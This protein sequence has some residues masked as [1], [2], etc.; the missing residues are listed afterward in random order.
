[1][2]YLDRESLDRVL[3]LVRGAADWSDVLRRAGVGR[4]RRRFP[5]VALVAAA[6]VV[7]VAGAASAFGTVRE[8]FFGTGVNS[9][10]AFIHNTRKNC[11]PHEL[12][13]M[14]ADGS[15][16]LRVARDVDSGFT[17]SPD[18]RQIAYSRIRRGYGH[19]IYVVNADG[20]GKRLLARKGLDPNWSPDGRR[21]VF[22]SHR[23]DNAE[24]YVMNADGSGQRNLTGTTTDDAH[25]PAWSPDGHT[26]AFASGHCSRP[27]PPP[28]RCFDLYAVNADGSGLRRLTR[29]TNDHAPAWSR[30]GRKI[31]FVSVR[32]GNREIYVM[33]ADGSG[34]QRLTRNRAGDYSP[35]WSP[36]GRK[37]AFVSQ[38]DG[39]VN[40]EIY[41]MNTLDGGGQRNLTRTPAQEDWFAWTVVP[42]K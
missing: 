12:W 26:I 31:A 13:I 6:A 39:N 22:F 28:A 4:P 5:R 32:D 10:I 15:K 18:E 41:V 24:L 36:D 3:P 27:Q 29:N 40:H 38:R 8:L 1:M 37:I 33:N 11:C 17:W 25:S 9:K 23:D 35:A 19:D 30:D 20:A 34:Q 14:N 2:T 16:P 7:L 21:I 42:T